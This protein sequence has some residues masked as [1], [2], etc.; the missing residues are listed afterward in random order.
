MPSGQ[1]LRRGA[2]HELID[3]G[4]WLT[5]L[6]AAAAAEL[7]DHL[8][9]PPSTRLT[10]DQQLLVRCLCGDR[11]P[12]SP[13]AAGRVPTVFGCFCYAVRTKL[14]ISRTL[15]EQLQIDSSRSIVFGALPH[16][17]HCQLFSR[18]PIV[19]FG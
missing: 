2:N 8:L 18:S 13:S 17:P 19:P 3:F 5:S 9:P 11:R 14:R 6:A 7:V 10:T 16:L 15:C 12:W 1:Q 4:C